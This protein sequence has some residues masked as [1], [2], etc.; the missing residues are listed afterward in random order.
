MSLAVIEPHVVMTVLPRRGCSDAGH[1]IRM[2]PDDAYHSRDV[3]REAVGGLMRFR[4]DG[5]RMGGGWKLETQVGTLPTI[6]CFSP[7][8]PLGLKVVPHGS[9]D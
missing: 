6:M 1:S 4:A 5:R 2:G 9:R 3:F 7:R 8:E